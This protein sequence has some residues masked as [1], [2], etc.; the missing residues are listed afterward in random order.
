MFKY[1]Y[2]MLQNFIIFQLFFFH[3]FLCQEYVELLLL[4]Y[5]NIIIIYFFASCKII[6]L[7]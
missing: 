7:I 6:I 4:I 5:V 2:I 3:Q 1:T